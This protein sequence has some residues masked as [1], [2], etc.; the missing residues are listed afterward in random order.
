[1]SGFLPA[2]ARWRCWRCCSSSCRCC[3]RQDAGTR[4][5][6]SGGRCAGADR[7]ERAALLTGSAIP[8]RPSRRGQRPE[9]LGQHRAAGAPAWSSNPRRS[10]RLAAARR[11]LWS[12]AGNTRWPC[13]PT[14]RP[15]H[16]PDGRS[17]TALTASV[18][19]LL[20]CGACRDHRPHRRMRTSSARCSWIRN[21]PR[22]CS[23]AAARRAAGRLQLA[24][25]RFAA[26]LTLTPPP[27][28]NVRV[29]LERQIDQIDAQ[30]HPAVDAAT[31]IRLHVSLAPRSPRGCRPTPRCSCS[32][33]SPDGGP[34]L[35]VKRSA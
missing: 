2:P 17:A 32:C 14:S 7:F 16:S 1:M 25:E 34:P 9:C 29:A 26:M 4:R 27:P 3:A 10:G 31:A 5:H 19:S 11:R 28:E 15:I 8:A 35:A 12:A 22:D 24:R 21:H 20:L 23:T 13:A 18:K 33:V 6:G 30:L